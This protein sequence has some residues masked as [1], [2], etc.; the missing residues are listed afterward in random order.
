VEMGVTVLADSFV[1]GQ[2]PVFAAMFVGQE[3]GVKSFGMRPP[4]SCVME[5][6]IRGTSAVRVDREQQPAVLFSSVRRS[7]AARAMCI[8]NH[9]DSSACPGNTTVPCGGGRPFKTITTRTTGSHQ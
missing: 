8:W 9:I 6:T 1:P 7:L 2:A 5:R 4:K 3:G